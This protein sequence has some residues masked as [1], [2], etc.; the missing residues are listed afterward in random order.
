[1]GRYRPGRGRAQRLLP[2]GLRDPR[3]QAGQLMPAGTFRGAAPEPGRSPVDAHTSAESVE[4]ALFEVKRVIVG[5]D[6][7][8]ERLFVALIAR[9][10]CLLEGAPC[11]AKPLAAAPPDPRAR[12]P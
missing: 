10:H 4:R 8:I 7:V 2:A 5:Q 3:H 1:A 12:G 6:R 11:L 9:G